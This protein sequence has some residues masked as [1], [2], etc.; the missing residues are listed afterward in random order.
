MT[1]LSP[2]LVGL[3]LLTAGAQAAAT[4]PAAGPVATVFDVFIG[5]PSSA[6]PAAAGALVVPGVV[7][8]LDAAGGGA[9]PPGAV[10]RSVALN[11]AV[12]KLWGTFRLDPARRLQASRRAALEIGASV[13]LPVPENVDLKL[14]ATLL[15]FDDVSATFKI[16]FRREGLVLADST[17]N[18]KRGGRAVVGG[19]DGPQ[20]PY[21]FAV[22]EPDQPGRTPVPSVDDMKDVIG[23]VAVTKVVAKYPGQ[24]R[25]AGLQGI[26]LLSVII[27]TSGQVVDPEV[28]DSPDP[29]LAQAAID[30][31]RQWRFQPARREGGPPLRVRM[32]MTFRFLLQP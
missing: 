9:P 21:V 14:Q 15:G 11:A 6:S 20:A 4:K 19:V 1:I 8:P 22:V 32:T 27:D 30:A 28:L 12:E 5:F 10:E 25:R 18:V 3:S 29:Q 31:V 24:A 2:A 13:D 16:V 17:V 26:V 7:I 23:P